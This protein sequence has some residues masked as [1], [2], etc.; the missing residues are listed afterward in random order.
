MVLLHLTTRVVPLVLALAGTIVPA[1][2]Q[3]TGPEPHE[4]NP[5]PSATTPQA[6]Q[7]MPQVNA[8]G[9]PVPGAMPGSQTVPSTI[10]KENAAADKQPIAAY[11]FK[12]LTADQRAEVFNALKGKAQSQSLKA[13]IGTE[14]PL[15]VALQPVPDALAAK[16]PRT[17]G[18]DYIAANNK[19]YL[20]QAPTRFVVGVFEAPNS[21]TTGSGAR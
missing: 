2:A 20:V 1:S 17:K 21:A 19:V 8:Q 5:G 11:T 10:S 16:V 15:S 4:A 12:M 9:Q 13:E 3:N 6:D 14:L 18:Y 7:H